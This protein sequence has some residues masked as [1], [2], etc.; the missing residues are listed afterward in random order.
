MLNRLPFIRLIFGSLALIFCAGTSLQA[1]DWPTRP[2]RFIVPFGQ[3][4][5]VDTVLTATRQSLEA[6]LGQKIIVEYRPGAGG[7]IGADFVFKSDPDGSTLLA[8]PPG[9]VAINHHLYKKLS[10]DPTR[11]QPITVMATVPNVLAVGPKVQAKNLTELI[12]YLKAN[13][14]KLSYASQGN[15]STSHLTASM[16]M[17]LTGTELIHIPYKGTA[18]ALVDL[19]AGTVDIFFDNL[20]SSMQFHQTG[21]IR[22]FAVADDQRS[23]ALPQVP[24]FSEQKLPG[25]QAVT[26]FSVM[27][28][29]GTPATAMTAIYKSFSEAL[30]NPEIKQKFLEQ[31]AEPRGWS[32][33]QTAKFVKD[34]SEKWQAV[35]KTTNVSLD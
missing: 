21:K 23:K 5:V 16:F 35:I 32:P 29:P 34:E 25:M 12:A 26:F 33:E 15:G 2:I 27:A 7:N 4:G 13:P 19:M 10:F 17:Q 30:A 20:S 1:Q 8:S 22:I 24:T 18:P 9:P 3:G 14:G 31:G 28:P 6:K 11:W